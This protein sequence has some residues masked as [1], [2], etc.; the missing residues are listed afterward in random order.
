MTIW[1]MRIAFWIPKAKNTHTGCVILIA[2]PLQQLLHERTS[3]LRYTYIACLVTYYKVLSC[4]EFS[5]P[6]MV[7]SWVMTAQSIVGAHRCFEEERTPTLM[8]EAAHF[9]RRTENQ[10]PVYMSEIKR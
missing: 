9:F 4:Q 2:F 3:V 1:R 7:V 10:L 5:T 8:R 6:D